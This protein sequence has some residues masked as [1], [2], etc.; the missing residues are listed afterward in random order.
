VSLTIT[1]LG[2]GSSGGVPRVSMGWGECDPA[3]PRNRRRRCSILVEQEGAGGKTVA[4]VDTSPD[5]REQLIDAD[6]KTLD[7]V[8]FTHSHADHTHGIDDLRPMAIQ[9]RRRIDAFVDEETATALKQRFDYIFA[10]P[11]GSEYPPLVDERRIVA[12]HRFSVSGQGGELD[13]LPMRLVHGTIDALG[14]RFGDIAY[15]PDLSAIPE[16]AEECLQGL[17]VWIID[18]LRYKRH[19]AHFSLEEAL[20]WIDRLKPRRAIL[21]NL[22]TDLDYERLKR[23]I[24]PHVEPAYDGMLIRG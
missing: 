8:I 5:L 24:P 10:T 18:A 13:V 14:L 6:V 16:A 3:N 12:G 19:P 17:D 15:T 9:L 11:P 2:C 22:H 23:E 4:V 21:T 20:Q 7:G 1:I